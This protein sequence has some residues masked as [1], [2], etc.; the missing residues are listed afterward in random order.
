MA[1]GIHNYQLGWQVHTM[2]SSYELNDIMSADVN[3][4]FDLSLLTS[5]TKA[6]IKNNFKRGYFLSN[7]GGKVNG[8]T[9]MLCE[10][11]SIDQLPVINKYSAW[12]YHREVDFKKWI[13]GMGIILEIPTQENMPYFGYYANPEKV[14]PIQIKLMH[15]AVKREYKKYISEENQIKYAKAIAAIDEGRTVSL[16]NSYFPIGYK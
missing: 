7:R 12:F 3:I 14:D 15:T 8:I 4:K 11:Y 6:G 10:K 1:A 16:A 13:K 5:R 9:K 2:I